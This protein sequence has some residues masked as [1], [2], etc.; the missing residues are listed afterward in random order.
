MLVPAAQF[1][2]YPEAVELY[3][4][5]REIGVGALVKTCGPP[6]FPFGDGMYYQLLIEEAE[7]TTAQATVEEFEQ[8]RAARPVVRCPKCGTPDP[9][10]IGRPVWWKRLYYAGTILHRCFNCEAE[11]PV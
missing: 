7:A 5:L 2:T 11:F 9:A 10:P 4:Q 1:L 3:S 8:Q 6:T